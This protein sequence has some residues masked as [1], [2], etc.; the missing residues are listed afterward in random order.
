MPNRPGA[1]TGN[2]PAPLCN[3]QG[4]TQACSAQTRATTS[5]SFRSGH[6]PSITSEHHVSTAIKQA[7][8]M[9]ITSRRAAHRAAAQQC[10][11]G[12]GF[13]QPAMSSVEP[14]DNHNSL[15]KLRS[16]V[17][18]KGAQCRIH[19]S[20]LNGK[21]HFKQPTCHVLCG[22]G[23]AGAHERLASS[24]YAHNTESLLIESHAA[25]ISLSVPC[26][27]R[28]LHTSV[29]ST[30]TLQVETLYSFVLHLYT[31]PSGW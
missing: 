18:S 30:N 12:P 2:R 19:I 4:A 20:G 16:R 8:L 22:T 27:T 29:L 24:F 31:Q 13:K 26:R 15:A 17:C 6:N 25:Y 5:R 3:Q 21:N 11:G 23:R 10:R 1:P 14:P 28:S 7:Q 9:H